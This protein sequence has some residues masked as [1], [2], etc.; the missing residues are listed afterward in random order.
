[1]Q[2]YLAIFTLLSSV[3]IIFTAAVMRSFGNPINWGLDMSLLL[4]TWSTFLSADVAYRNNK[5]VHVD[6]FVNYLP[7]KA[8]KL[9][10][11][12][13]YIIVL[14]FLVTMVRLGIRLCIVSV[15]RTFQGIP[16]L[17]YTWLALSVP[18]GFSMMII[19]TLR[20]IYF[21]YIRG[22]S[23]PIPEKERAKS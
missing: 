16:W 21:E 8:R 7:E 14:V 9:L 22:I 20:K 3:T 23:A 17:S 10:R 15:A 6:T 4:F 12:A 13:C 2:I 1:L 18:V 5:V 19:T 11:L